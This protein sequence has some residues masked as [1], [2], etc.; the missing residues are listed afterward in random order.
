MT[1]AGSHV[2]PSK[3][4]GHGDEFPWAE[5]PRAALERREIDVWWHLRGRYPTG[6]RGPAPVRSSSRGDATTTY[7]PAILS[8]QVWVRGSHSAHR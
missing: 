3:L 5:I 7:V 4:N 1:A 6:R 2:L 8:C